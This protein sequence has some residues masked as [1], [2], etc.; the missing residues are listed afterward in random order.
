[1]FAFGATSNT[2][3]NPIQAS[4]ATAGTTSGFPFTT[5][6][7]AAPTFGSA[8]S[9]FAFGGGSTFSFGSS[10]T[11]PASSGPFQFSASPAPTVNNP[12]SSNFSTVAPP[13]PETKYESSSE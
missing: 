11:A 4:V 8:P 10:S 6:S 13:A 3:T 7:T 2:T 9:T 12:L 1:L 5:P